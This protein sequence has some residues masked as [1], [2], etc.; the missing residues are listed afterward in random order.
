MARTAGLSNERWFKPHFSAPRP[1]MTE[2][3][4]GS[5]FQQPRDTHAAM[6]EVI[7]ELDPTSKIGAIDRPTLA[8]TDET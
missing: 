8:L 6:W 3:T 5:L 4:R 1:V 7:A 2:R